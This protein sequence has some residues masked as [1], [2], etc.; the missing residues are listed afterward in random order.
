[1]TTEDLP[2]ALTM[3][4]RALAILEEQAAGFGTLHIP[5]H[6]RI[7]LEEKRREVADLEAQLEPLA[8]GSVPPAPVY[9]QREQAV[10]TQINVA[11][12]YHVT[13]ASGD[14]SIAIGGNAEGNTFNMGDAGSAAPA[15]PAPPAQSALISRLYQALQRLDDTEIGTLCLLHCPAIYDKFGRGQGRHEMVKVVLEH[16]TRNPEDAAELL[17]HLQ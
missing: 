3:A 7:E 2:R 15:S 8:G 4:R 6:L 9:D 13:T 5:T 11:G 17:S 12:D 16:C 1:M 10:N 14:R